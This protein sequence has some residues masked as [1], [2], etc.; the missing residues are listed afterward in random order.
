M[1]QEFQ[2]EKL[3]NEYA[4]QLVSHGFAKT[5]TIYYEH[6]LFKVEFKLDETVEGLDGMHLV[7]LGARP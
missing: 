3:A 6:E 4:R 2:T 1:T 7:D 5:A